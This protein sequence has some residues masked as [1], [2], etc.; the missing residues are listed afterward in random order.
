MKSHWTLISQIH[1]D[2]GALLKV[3]CEKL[4]PIVSILDSESNPGTNT[5]YP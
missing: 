5:H 2:F 4:R 3:I 1:A